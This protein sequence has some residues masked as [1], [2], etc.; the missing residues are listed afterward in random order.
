MDRHLFRFV[1]HLILQ[2]DLQG[3]RDIIYYFNQRYGRRVPSGDPHGPI[4]SN[5]LVMDI[6][7]GTIGYGLVVARPYRKVSLVTTHVR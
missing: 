5:N 3:V 7:F 6:A 2:E 1:I 4:P